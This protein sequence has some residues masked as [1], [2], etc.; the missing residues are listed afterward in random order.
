MVVPPKMTHI[1]TSLPPTVTV[2]SKNVRNASAILRHHLK[3]LYKNVPIFV[4]D[5]DGDAVH[6]WL[7]VGNRLPNKL[8]NDIDYPH[9]KRYK[10]EDI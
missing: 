2:A 8:E 3:R 5:G 6:P 10:N 7:M 9:Y 1:D 4:V